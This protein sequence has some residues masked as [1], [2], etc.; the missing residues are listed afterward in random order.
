LTALK[1]EERKGT[2]QEG[3]NHPGTVLVV[4]D[5]GIIRV[6]SERVLKRAGYQV[7]T[8]ECGEEALT[9]MGQSPSE[10]VMLDIKMPGLSGVEVLRKIKQDWPETEVVIMTAYA[11]QDIAEES[12][13]L[14]ASEILLKPVEDINLIIGSVTKAMIRA[15]IKKG[16]GLD[17]LTFEQLLLTQGLVSPD[18]ID[19]AKKHSAQNN[20]PLRQSVVELKMVSQDEIDWNAAQFLE[21]PYL[22]VYEKMLDPELIKAFPPSLARKH[23]CLPLWKEDNLLHVVM[24]DP[25]D[26]KAVREMEKALQLKVKPAKGM[27]GELAG[28]VR[29]F[30]GSRSEADEWEQLVERLKSVDPA[31]LRKALSEVLAHANLEQVLEASITPGGQGLFEF[32]LHALLKQP[33]GTEV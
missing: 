33:G 10:V 25:F 9:K 18:N 26:N 30:Y 1:T 11:D 15:R 22:R 14:G 23:C 32:R 5:A 16:G 13:N 21:I 12:L 8:A 4:D 28:L 19:T 31:E 20:Q 6:T 29:K 7:A 2:V 27:G 24:N 3:S 17:D